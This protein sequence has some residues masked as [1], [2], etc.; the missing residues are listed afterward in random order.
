[1]DF[2]IESRMIE[3]VVIVVLVWFVVEVARG[4]MER[5]ADH[6]LSVHII[7]KRNSFCSA[8]RIKPR[9]F[10]EKKDPIREDRA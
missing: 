8:N 1:M 2:L 4:D 6:A 7:F 10:N 9:I 5:F 3:V